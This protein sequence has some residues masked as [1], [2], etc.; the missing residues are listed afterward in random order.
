ME[1]CFISGCLVLNIIV[2]I[3]CASTRPCLCR[4]S[5][6]S[7]R[8]EER[9]ALIRLRQSL[10]DPDGLLLSWVGKDCCKWE[11]IGC[12]AATG[13][14]IRLELLPRFQI[15]T[16]WYGR[17]GPVPQ[18]EQPF[19][20]TMLRP[21]LLKLKHLNHL[22]LTGLSLDEKSTIPKFISS[23]KQ[24]RYLN[25]SNMGFNG[26]VPCHLANLTNL[27]VLDLRGNGYLSISDAQWVSHLVALKYLDLSHVHLSEA[28]NLMQALSTLPSL[29][30]L[31]LSSCGLDDF[32]LSHSRLFNS[33]FLAD[34][35]Y[36][37]LS[38]NSFRGQFAS[39]FQ[40]MTSLNY[41]D[42]SAN[43]VDSFG[44]PFLSGPN[45]E[46]LDISSNEFQGQI[47]SA[48]RNMTSLAYLDLSSN[49]FSSVPTWFISLKSLVHMDLSATNL[50]NPVGGLILRDKCK[51]R[52]LNLD[53]IYSHR[54]M[55]GNSTGFCASNLESLSAISIHQE[56]DKLSD[57]IGNLKNL[58]FLTLPANLFTGPVPDTWGNLRSL[59]KLDL[60][61]NRLQ[62]D[63]PRWLGQLQSLQWLDLSD[64]LFNGTI[65]KSLGRIPD[66]QL[67]D[68]SGNSMEGTVTEVHLANISGLKF[69]DLSDNHLTIKI[70]SDWVPPFQLEVIKMGSCN[71]E[72]QFPQWLRMQKHFYTLILSDASISGVIPEWFGHSSPS[73]AELSHNLLTIAF[74]K[75]DLS[76]NQISGWIPANFGEN[77]RWLSSL[78]LN[79][80]LISGSIPKSL[81]KLEWLKEIDL[82]GN[83]L[84]GSI[85][86]CWKD[87]NSRLFKMN[88]SF[89]NLSGLIPSS[90]G[91]LS[92]LS[93]LHL[94]DNGLQGE[95]PITMRFLANLVFLDLGEN[96]LSGYLPSWIGKD[97]QSLRVLRLRKNQFNGGI[98][99]EFCS[100]TQLKWMDMALNHLSGAIPHCFGHLWGMTQ[101]FDN[102][103]AILTIIANPFGVIDGTSTSGIVKGIELDYATSRMLS[104]PS[105]DLS[106]NNLGSTPKELAHLLGLRFLNLSHNLLSGN[107]P[108]NIGV[109]KVLESLDVSDNRLSGEIPSSISNLTFLAYLDLS[110]N[111]FSGRIPESNQLD[112]LY[113]AN[114]FIYAGNPL[115][116]GDPLPNRCPGDKVPE[117]SKNPVEEENGSKSDSSEKIVLYGV[118]VVGF[119]TGFWG[120]IGILI[121]KKSWRVA[122]FRLAEVA[123]D[124][125][126]VAVTV[127]VTK[128]KRRM[129]SA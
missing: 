81:C 117:P 75:I 87:S 89:N 96:N 83:R 124:Q 58:K 102:I 43:S 90:I 16:D 23:M 97:L 53:R 4:N 122:Y 36:L 76:H 51:L 68:F 47:P 41:L 113:R 54:D 10:S 9:D 15:Y 57:Q 101:E 42:I 49:G 91:N 69:L 14:V 32:H 44:S 99:L 114:P 25:L 20:A 24:M 95:P 118:V 71:F 92:R 17:V 106:R 11:G 26:T 84:S 39:P 93:F 74:S 55:I 40:N 67:L 18:S 28:R 35:H 80:N 111:F 107:I 31:S 129:R 85:P 116:C 30:H 5:T 72:R 3:L 79:D 56:E 12:D 48:L 128:L 62:G 100:L 123:V 29:S 73:N 59:I 121:F 8:E 78:L 105:M 110:S 50:T 21:Y 70:K 86:N 64:N 119:S 27:E 104:V 127:K 34:L 109:M 33:S 120:V 37:D 82:S 22:D 7:C 98:P 125:V 126:Y 88:L 46:H 103:S 94:N 6:L 52:F 2:F 45:L 112:T 1:G 65:P 13:H 60:S 77:N 66:L 38:F 115:L 19:N 108:E 63:L 61:S